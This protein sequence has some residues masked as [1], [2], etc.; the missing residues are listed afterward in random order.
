MLAIPIRI[1]LMELNKSNNDNKIMNSTS[2][3]TDTVTDS[4]LRKTHPSP[5]M[6][7]SCFRNHNS[8]A[9]STNQVGQKAEKKEDN[10]D[11]L[12]ADLIPSVSF[13]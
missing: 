8:I 6:F 9:P 2:A 4:T 10:S 7:L 1:K 12:F 13:F 5:N 11:L 3:D